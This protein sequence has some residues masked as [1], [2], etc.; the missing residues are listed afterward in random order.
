M[1]NRA[2]IDSWTSTSTVEACL[3]R[4]FEW[5][6]QRLVSLDCLWGQDW[7]DVFYWG[8]G[9]V[10]TAA[11][12][13]SPVFTPSS[14]THLPHLLMSPSGSLR[15]LASFFPVHPAPHPW[16]WASASSALSLCS[17]PHSSEASFSLF[18]L[19]ITTPSSTLLFWLLQVFSSLYSFPALGE[20]E[21]KSIYS[22]SYLE[23][24]CFS[25]VFVFFFFFL[26]RKPDDLCILTY[27]L[28]H[29]NLTHF[30][31]FLGD[32]CLIFLACNLIL[33]VRPIL[34][35]L[36]KSTHTHTHTHI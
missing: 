8:C 20:K 17:I 28:F 35:P 32:F 30:S 29:P 9:A 27:M 11:L 31:S 19:I 14:Y 33:Q 36:F 22:V 23:L 26:N 10:G 5:F 12:F 21:D 3:Y 6:C 25:A 16:V 4:Q 15:T 1:C 18:C 34:F 13:N 24:E 7:K 2:R